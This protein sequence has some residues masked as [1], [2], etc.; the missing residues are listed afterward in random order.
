[1]KAKDY[2][3]ITKILEKK[4][5]KKFYLFQDFE[6]VINRIKKIK[7]VRYDNTRKN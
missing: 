7:G 6:D 4:Y 3:S 1:M 2:K 5:K